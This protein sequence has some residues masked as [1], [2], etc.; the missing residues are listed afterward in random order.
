MKQ[1][2]CISCGSDQLLSIP[3]YKRDWHC[4]SDCGTAVAEDRAQYPLR[5]L[6]YP[7]LKRSQNLD[8]E[9][10]YDYFV[11]DIHVNW[12]IREGR[13]FLND[14]LTTQGIDIAGKTVLDISGGNG[15]VLKQLELAGASVTLTE[16]NHKTI[17]Y[18]HRTHGFPV[19][20]YNLNKHDL[21]EVTG[22]TYDIILLRACIMFAHNLPQL[23]DQLKR[24]LNPGGMVI[25]NHSVIPTLG[26]MLRVQLDE[27]S[28]YALRQPEAII[29]AFTSA[30]FQL[31]RRLDE[32]D[33]SLY[34]YDHDLLFRWKALHY[35]YELL[36][37][38]RIGKQRKFALP[39]R[40]RR[41]TTLY[42]RLG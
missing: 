7:D 34:V 5:F 38:K 21:Q 18:A 1:N 28:Y 13:E 6:P 42:F 22:K 30:D 2:S 12:S 26:V 24:C 40:D 41:R 23:I 35:F 9:K 11:D 14:F 25:V 15:H 16:I 19:Y 10:M 39:A 8:E 32:T 4:C 27:F 17:D 3:T 20:E 36:G 31:H 37:I 33:P 29:N